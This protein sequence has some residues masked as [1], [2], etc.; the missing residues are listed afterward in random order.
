M[1]K[2]FY[3]QMWHVHMIFCN[4]N[5]F[6]VEWQVSV[7]SEELEQSEHLCVLPT[8]LFLRIFVDYF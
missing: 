7:S 8:S 1:W 5:V 6:L 2:A 3:I 4:I